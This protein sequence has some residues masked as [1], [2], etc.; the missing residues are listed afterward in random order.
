[1]SLAGITCDHETEMLILTN[2]LKQVF[3]SIKYL[4]N[5]IDPMPG[6]DKSSLVHQK[7]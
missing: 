4:T 5:V 7:V 3:E 2:Y 6:K 1:M